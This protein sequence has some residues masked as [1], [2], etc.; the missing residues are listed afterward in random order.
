MLSASKNGVNV[1]GF[2][3][4][5]NGIGQAARGYARAFQKLSWNVQCGDISLTPDTQEPLDFETLDPKS[6]SNLNLIVAN[7]F[8]VQ[9]YDI[10]KRLGFDLLKRS[11]N[12]G[13][14][15]WEIDSPPPMSWHKGAAIFD[16]IWAGTDFVKSIFE[17]NFELPVKTVPPLVELFP[18]A[19]CTRDHFSWGEDETIFLFL[20]DFFSIAERKN[21]LNLIKA[22]RSAFSKDEKARLVIKVINEAADL[23]YWQ[24]MRDACG[25]ARISLVNKKLSRTDVDSMMNLADCYVSLHRAEGF[26]L[27]LA[28]SMLGAKPVIATGYS[29]NMDFMSEDNSYLVP[30]E[31]VEI[32]REH[33]PYSKG[34]IWAEPDPLI[35]GQ[36]MREVFENPERARAKG[37]KAREV[38]RQK[39]SSQ[40]IAARINE[41]VSETDY[42]MSTGRFGRAVM[43]FSSFEPIV[44]EREIVP[45]VPFDQSEAGLV[46]VCLPV[47][48]GKDY[49]RESVESVLAQTYDNFE[50][51]ISD[52]GSTDGSLEIIKGF[53]Q[54]D[55]RI[56][57][58]QNK[59]R[60]GLFEN[61]NRCMQVARGEF[62]KPFAQD[63]V[64]DSKFLG[65]AVTALRADRNISLFASRRGFINEVNNKL[66]SEDLDRAYRSKIDHDVPVSGFMAVKQC[67]FPVMNKIGEP[68]T[69][70]FRREF[71]GA[72]FD[73]S[74]HHTGDLDYWFRL[75]RNGNFF[76]T[77]DVLC[78]FRMHGSSTSIGNIKSLLF[79]LD[80]IRLGRKHEITLKRM[81]RSVDEYMAQELANIAGA[82]QN[83]TEGDL[84]FGAQEISNSGKHIDPIEFRELAFLAFRRPGPPPSLYKVL[85][86]IEP[87]EQEIRT[88]LSSPSWKITKPL[89]DFKKR[90]LSSGAPEIIGVDEAAE[91]EAFDEH[92]YFLYLASLRT[93]I[94]SSGSWSITYPLRKLKIL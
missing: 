68:A 56:K 92:D 74:F 63:D 6:A 53:A 59:T 43:N 41:L 55:K 3:S 65:R 36:L 58:W 60:L 73:S 78:Y 52:D 10:D 72:G 61:Y 54:K 94:L 19:N 82:V 21:P 87:L 29:G 81:K 34:S 71:I 57:F 22:F 80:L 42:S 5:T 12:I 64:L 23:Q 17:K 24:A 49:L 25:D 8:P 45:D 20:C 88:L 30:Y 90:F 47:F 75:L 85:S 18:K 44:E 27:T 4:T 11:Y 1:I 70:M 13:S 9:I 33:R 91:Y 86:K 51:L 26:G 2:L 76:G 62:I 89:R 79:A 83:L 16:E 69:V 28:E 39:Y 46:S 31:L 15:W 37:E 77:S 38:I 40:A 66:Q 50:L 7:P 84:F 32:D 14:W 93:A 48:N 35:A 67:F